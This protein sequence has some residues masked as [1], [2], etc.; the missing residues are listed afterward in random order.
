M[1]CLNSPFCRPKY[2]IKQWMKEI[3]RTYSSLTSLKWRFLF[4]FLP[5]TAHRW[6]SIT[7]CRI[8]HPVSAWMFLV[9]HICWSQIPIKFLQ[10]PKGTKGGCR[11]RKQDRGRQGKSSR[12]HYRKDKLDV[13][14]ETSGSLLLATRCISNTGSLWSYA[15]LMKWKS[16]PFVQTGLSQLQQL[17]FQT[18]KKLVW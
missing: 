11:G 13:F 1:S 12:T 16:N 18:K 4:I 14:V 6:L 8:K 15:V 2:L 7:P 9:A 17:S 10:A 5:L 3:T